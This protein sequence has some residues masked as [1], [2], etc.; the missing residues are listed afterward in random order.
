[1]TIL[2]AD[3]LTFY[4]MQVLDSDA[5]ERS[6]LQG[7]SSRENRLLSIPLS[8]MGDPSAP[9]KGTRNFGLT[10]DTR[11]TGAGGFPFL[12]GYTDKTPR[13]VV[14]EQDVAGQAR[15]PQSLPEEPLQQPET[16]QSEIE[17]LVHQPGTPTSE[18]E[19]VPGANTPEDSP[20]FGPGRD[21]PIVPPLDSRPASQILP[22]NTP[23]DSPVFGPGL[24]AP[25]VPRM[26]ASARSIESAFP[27]DLPAT[28]TDPGGGAQSTPRK[29][30]KATLFDI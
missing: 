29:E 10:L 7:P 22:A 17:Q 2:H 1:M 20:I 24:D 6:Q 4:L 16:P 3:S 13:P 27:S 28:G 5:R 11:A 30:G 21:V 23:E 14:Q 26:V 9:K 8:T 15:T 19:E 25:P 18:I 12:A